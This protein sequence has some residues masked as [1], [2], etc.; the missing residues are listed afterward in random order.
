MKNFSNFTLTE[1]NVSTTKKSELILCFKECMNN[2]D[3]YAG[4]KPTPKVRLLFRNY[5]VYKTNS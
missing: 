3:E 4:L 5:K 2:R 1:V